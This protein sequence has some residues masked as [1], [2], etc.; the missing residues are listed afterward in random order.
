MARRRLPLFVVVGVAVGLLVAGAALGAKRYA[1]RMGDVKSGSGPDIA[2]VNVSNTATRITFGIRFAGAPPLRVSTREKWVDMLLMGIDV[3]PLGPKPVSPGGEW[4]GM[5]F[6]LGTHGPSTT[7]QVVRL[8]GKGSRQVARLKVVTTGSTITFSVARSAL[9]N[10]AWFTFNVAA[11]RE[12]NEPSAG[13]GVDLA[14]D[15]GSFRY[16]LA[17]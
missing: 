14:P 6:A 16:V 13:G 15:R 5:D 4:R 9:G 7:G 17:R 1:D 12:E 2:A 11:A 10:P 3:P 8:A